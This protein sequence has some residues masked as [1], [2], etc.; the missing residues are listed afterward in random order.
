MAPTWTATATGSAVSSAA[1]LAFAL[2]FSVGA[3]SGPAGL[4][5]ET[6]KAAAENFGECAGFWSVSEKAHRAGGQPANADQARMTGNGALLVSAWALAMRHQALDRDA[7]P[8]PIGA[9]TARAE[10]IRDVEETRLL[11]LMER[12]EETAF[13]A[14]GRECH[15]LLSEQQALIDHIRDVAQGQ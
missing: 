4:D 7:L 11:A 2:S 1:V 9:F 6:L 15:E 14:A 8:K 13:V 3:A 12:G 5:P 10:G